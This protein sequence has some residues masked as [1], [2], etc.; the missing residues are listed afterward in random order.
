MLGLFFGLITYFCLF[1]KFTSL[2]LQNN[3]ESLLSFHLHFAEVKM[4]Q[5]RD[6]RLEFHGSLPCVLFVECTEVS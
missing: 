6:R 5:A 1:F 3:L 2:F 4:L